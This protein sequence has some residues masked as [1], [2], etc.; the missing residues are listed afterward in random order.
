MAKLQWLKLGNTGC[1]GTY[2]VAGAFGTEATIEQEESDTFGAVCGPGNGGVV[3]R[4]TDPCPGCRPPTFLTTVQSTIAGSC[5]KA[6]INFV[7]NNVEQADT[8]PGTDGEGSIPCVSGASIIPPSIP[9]VK[10]D[11]DMRMKALIRILFLDN[12]RHGAKAVPSV[13]SSV[14]PDGLTTY[15][16]IQQKLISLRP[17]VG[18]DG[19]PVTGCGDNEKEVGSPQDRE[20]EAESDSNFW[21]S[22]GDIFAWPVKWLAGIGSEEAGAITPVLEKIL[23]PFAPGIDLLSDLAGEIPESENHRLMI[24]STR[25][26]NNQLIIEA[27]G[28][29]GQASAISS[30]QDGAKSWL[31]NKFQS[32]AKN[33]FIEYNARPY[34]S[35]SLTALRNLADFATDDNVKLGARMLLEY[36]AAKFAVGSNQ[37]RRLVPFRRRLPAVKCIMRIVP[38]AEC[39]TNACGAH[40]PPFFEIFHPKAFDDHEVSL[41]LLFNGQTQQLPGGMVPIDAVDAS[42]ATSEFIIDPL[43]ADLGIRKEVP[44]LQRIRHAG[45]EIYSSSA[46]ALITAGGIETDHAYQFTVGG[47]PKNT[48]WDKTENIG[49]GLPT[50]VMFTGDPLGV[51]AGR[52]PSRMTNGDF[53]TLQGNV[54]TVNGDESFTD[55]LCVWRNFACG[56][57]VTVPADI[58]SCLVQAPSQPVVHWFFFDSVTCPGYV[59]GSK[60]YFVMYLIC[61]Q[62]QCSSTNVP[63][64]SAGFLEIVDNPTQPFQDFQNGVLA[65]NKDFQNSS[66]DLENLG[67]G[68]LS[69]GD[70]TGHYQTFSG[71]LLELDLRGHQD[72]SHKTGILSIDKVQETDLIQWG[73]GQGDNLGLSPIVAKHDG[74]I[75]IMNNNPPLV[76]QIILDFSNVNHPV[77]R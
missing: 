10:G 66:G 49:A 74:I 19:Y 3:Q 35:L 53:I 44:Y 70:C 36:S 29:P 26:L 18:R 42:A 13:L 60:F 21:N 71:H 38:C 62:N 14:R 75:T 77:M 27:L 6:Q 48:A 45:Y 64:N 30:A 11:W 68:C 56:I 54:E 25:F 17:D 2:S 4:V 33:D 24:E 12:L 65:A 39:Y 50:T 32:I 51:T 5:L 8:Y 59:F 76:G 63:P 67:Q 46:S 61:Q 72:D 73:L 41:G 55:N 28:G 40:E 31:L 37:G 47:F 69:G 20:D 43:I 15:D 52:E 23:G 58:T 57:N 34:Q 1:S 7:L 16:Y 9:N 22:I